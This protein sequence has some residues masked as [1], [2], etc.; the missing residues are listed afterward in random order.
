MCYG[1]SRATD[2]MLDLVAQHDLKPDGIDEINVRIGTT[3]AL[4]LRNHEP[5]TGLEAKFSLEFAM[6]SALVV[7]R[8]GMKELTDEFVRRDDIRAVMRK[9]RTTTTEEKMED[10]PFAPDDRVNVVLASGET[11][12][13]EPVVRPKGSWQKPLT[14]SEL[15]EKFSDCAGLVMPAARSDALF[16]RLGNIGRLRSLRELPLLAA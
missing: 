9:V 2:A 1:A 3:Q 15:K 13:H 8:V 16:E 7:R 4:M 10:M 12:A 14:E 11:L 5:Q 6:A